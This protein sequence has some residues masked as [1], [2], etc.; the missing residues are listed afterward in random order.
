MA[1]D[2]T[3]T[4]K[5]DE[6]S[7]KGQTSVGKEGITPPN[8]TKAQVDKMI[9]DAKSEWGRE[10]APLKEA[11]KRLSSLESERDKLQKEKDELE[12]VV[13]KDNPVAY[14]VIKGK[15]ALK[16]KEIEIEKERQKLEAEKLEQVP[17]LSKIEQFNKREKAI[18]IASKFEGVDANVLL[19]VTDG[20][21]EKM[22]ALAETLGK[23]K[24]EAEQII[25][26]S[27]V[28][29]GHSMTWERAQKEF[30]ENPYNP[31][32]RNEYLRFRQEKGIPI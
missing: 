17:T 18:E 25:P 21:S 13:A 6:L 4:A 16:A 9:L 14:D 30:A 5:Q 27:G 22:Q 29:A 20:T 32:V 15:Q 12:L 10:V 24:G 8:Y 1:K 11:S 2:E 28:G 7:E 26:D 3:N 19:S 23:P 31:S